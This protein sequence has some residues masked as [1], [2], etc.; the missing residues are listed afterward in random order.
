MT[1]PGEVITVRVGELRQF[2]DSIDP[3]PFRE[4]DLDPKVE[5]FI[6]EWAREVPREVPLSL[7]VCIEGT[8]MPTVDNAV[9]MDA[10]HQFFSYRATSTNRRLKRLF[11]EGRISL[12]IGLLAVAGFTG[13][14]QLVAQRMTSGFGEILREG[15]AIAGWVAMWRPIEIFLYEWWPI[16]REQRLYARLS[17]LPVLVEWDAVSGSRQKVT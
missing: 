7:R 1:A 8:A 9:V 16:R 2:F 3:A 6:V 10:V 14:S 4:R 12:F 13:L 11:G 15:L 17:T 5:N